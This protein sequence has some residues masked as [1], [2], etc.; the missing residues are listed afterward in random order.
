MT[1]DFLAMEIKETSEIQNEG[2]ACESSPLQNH[3]C[4]RCLLSGSTPAEPALCRYNV[5]KLVSTDNTR[6]SKCK[7]NF[8]PKR[9]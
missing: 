7:Q 8:P 6:F 2:R 4:W 3:R 5:L 9:R 1:E